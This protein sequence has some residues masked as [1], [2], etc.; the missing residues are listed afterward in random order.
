MK[1]LVGS[2]DFTHGLDLQLLVD[3][4]S[5]GDA[6]GLAQKVSAQI[7]EAKKSRQL[8]VLGLSS[9]VEAVKAESQ[10]A[11]FKLSMKLDQRQVDDLVGR[12]MALFQSA[13]PRLGAGLPG[14]AAPSL[15][16]PGG[17]GGFQ[18]TFPSAAP[19]LKLN[20]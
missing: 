17:A 15:P 7:D 11:T 5:E 4:G 19:R 3:L 8:M 18:P 20:P 2:L 16:S 12:A 13:A 1:D 14:G 9:L 10:G 6:S